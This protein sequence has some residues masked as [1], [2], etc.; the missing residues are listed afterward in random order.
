MLMMSGEELSFLCFCYMCSDTIILG[1]WFLSFLIY[2]KI[3]L[4]LFI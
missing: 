4:L 1:I 2:C 3:N